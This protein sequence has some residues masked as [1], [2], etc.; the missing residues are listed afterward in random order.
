MKVIVEHDEEVSAYLTQYARGLESLGEGYQTLDIEEKYHLWLSETIG[1]VEPN[2]E[3]VLGEDE[4]VVTREFIESYNMIWATIGANLHIDRA[5]S[6]YHLTEHTYQIALPNKEASNSLWINC[7]SEKQSITAVDYLKCIHYLKNLSLEFNKPILIYANIYVPNEVFRYRTLTYKIINSY[8]TA[9]QA[10]LITKCINEDISQ[11]YAVSKKPYEPYLDQIVYV[12][13]STR[14]TLRRAACFLESLQDKRC[15]ENTDKCSRERGSLYEDLFYQHISDEQEIYVFLN[16]GNFRP[17]QYYASLGV[18]IIPL[19][20]DYGMLYA[21]KSLFESLRGVLMQEVAHPYYISILSHAPCHKIMIDQLSPQSLIKEE[22]KYKGRGVYIGV[23]SSDEV[24]YTCE[25]LRTEK[26]ASRIACIWQQEK[27]TIG[28]YYLKEQISE[29]IGSQNPNE[30]IKIPDGDSISTMMLTIAGGESKDH[31]Y[32]GIATEAEFVVAKINKAPD[33]VQRIYGGIPSEHAVMMP[34]IIIGAL[35]LIDFAREQGKPLVLCIPFNN[36]VDPHDGSLI[37][38]QILGNM[39]QSH[40]L[41][42]IVTAGEEADKM[43][44]YGIEGEEQFSKKIQLRVS[45][46]HQN[47]VG[48][49]YQRFANFLKV[50][51]HPPRE[52]ITH[53][54]DLK[55][56]AVTK[57]KETII[58]SNGDKI[59]FLNGASRILF[60]LENPQVGEWRIEIDSQTEVLS[61]IDI[62]ISQQELNRHITLHP[63]SPF[64]TIGSLAATNNV[65]SIGGYDK[66]NMVVLKSSGRG[67]SWDNRVKPLF[68]THGSNIIAPCRQGKWIATTGVLPATSI[69]LGVAATLYSKFVEEKVFPF[70]NTL[71]MN[72]IMLSAVK[73]LDGN[74][75]P[76]PSQGYG[77][78]D[79]NT[80]STLLAASYGV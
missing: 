69:I 45:K 10:I 49:I 35:K 67:Y 22:L 4:E 52:M 17:V 80:L 43:H 5:D 37:R 41:T 1:A 28:K 71:V 16:P 8:L 33:A 36:N 21:K 61:Q 70:P 64:I 9:T 23:I 78:F 12:S 39:A 62:W 3:I 59:S 30:H 58:Y 19:M 47:V 20:G 18:D 79:L 11:Y 57:V 76:N 53:P 38:H 75:Y 46:E 55:I 72:S 66:K 48:V 65:M 27:V 77:I 44:H 31:F 32:K 7:S 25:A 26:G 50:K 74:V 40:D 51:L 68:V 34:D 63:A 2:F 54:V 42:I 60:R 14:E 73:Q 56:P 6:F 15:C 24:D 13:G 29:A